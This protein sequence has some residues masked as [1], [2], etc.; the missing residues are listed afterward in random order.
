MA[1]PDRPAV[2][3]GVPGCRVTVHAAATKMTVRRNPTVGKDF[4]RKFLPLGSR[5]GNIHI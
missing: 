4:D 3:R 1:G 2:G 5:T